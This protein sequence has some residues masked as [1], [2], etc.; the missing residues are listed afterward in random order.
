MQN[1]TA[2]VH[3]CL[4]LVGDGVIANESF[5]FVLPSVIELCL[6]YRHEL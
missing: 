1:S 6:R 3:Y 4:N 5:Y 2:L